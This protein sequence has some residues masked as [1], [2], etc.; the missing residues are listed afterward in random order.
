MIER[1][2]FQIVILLSIVDIVSIVGI[3]G[4]VVAI[5][6]GCYWVRHEFNK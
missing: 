5:G 3:V 1:K 2:Y 6:V 4:I